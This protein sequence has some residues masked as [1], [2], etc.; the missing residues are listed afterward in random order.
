MAASKE[1]RPPSGLTILGR[2]AKLLGIGAAVLIGLLLVAV[3]A[4]QLS[5]VRK[6]ILTRAITRA[7]QSVTGE[8]EVEQ[9]A[10]PRLTRV[11][12][13]G[14]RW[15]DEGDTLAAAE[16]V[17]LAFDLGAL[18]QRHLHVR[19][20]TLLGAR[21]DLPA[22]QER[23]G[24][25]E[26][27]TT[28]GEGGGLPWI[29]EG[30]MPGVPSLAADHIEIG[31]P[32]ICLSPDRS[33]NDLSL[34]AS[35]DVR[36]GYSRSARIGRFHFILPQDSVAI[37]E[38][39]LTYT[40]SGERTLDAD[41]AGR[42]GPHWPIHLTASLERDEDLQLFL[43]REEGVPPPR[44]EG[45]ALD[46]RIRRR[47]GSI[48]GLAGNARLEIPAVAELAN[49]PILRRPLAGA[50]QFE[51]IGLEVGGSV[52]WRREV[53]GSVRIDVHPGEWMRRGH[54]AMR[55]A[56][57]ELI[58]DSIS[59]ELADLVVEGRW[60]RRAAE[61]EGRIK[62]RI[63][64]AEWLRPFADP[65][66]LPD[67]VDLKLE[68]QVAG[69]GDALQVEGRLEGSLQAAGRRLDDLS[70]A[71]SGSTDPSRPIRFG[72]A[73]LSSNLVL[74]SAGALATGEEMR[75]RLAPLRLREADD[76]DS[77][78]ADV[79]A[80]GA[81]D[82]EWGVVTY[83]AAGGRIGVE[84]VRVE[85]SY[86]RASIS[87]A[88][89]RGEG[90]FSSEIAWT[91]PPPV[92]VSRT[93]P[94]SAARSRLR[95]RWPEEGPYRVRAE[96]DIAPGE[97]G[98]RIDAR[99]TLH[100]PGPAVLAPAL[101]PQADAGDLGPLR[102]TATFQTRPEEPAWRAELDLSETDWLEAFILEASGGAR[103]RVDTLNLRGL[104]VALGARGRISADSLQAAARL[105]I[106]N[107]RLM[108]RLAPAA[109]ESTDAT[110]TV[111]A[112]ASGSPDAPRLEARFE[113]ALER[114]GLDLPRLEGSAS[115]AAQDGAAVGLRLP[116]SFHLGAFF[117]D[118]AMAYARIP[119]DTTAARAG[120]A[121]V[122]IHGDLLQLQAS[123]QFER[124]AGWEIKA[125][126]FAVR[127]SDAG[128]QAQTPFEIRLGGERGGLA[129]DNVDLEGGLGSIKGHAELDS[130]A[131]DVELIA[132]LQLPERPP[133]PA[134]PPGLWPHSLQLDLRAPPRDTLRAELQA[135]GLHIGPEEDVTAVLQLTQHSR[136]IAFNLKLDGEGEGLLAAEGDYPVTIQLSPWKLT[137]RDTA[138][139]ARVNLEQFPLPAVA[140]R[141]VQAP[142]YL[143]RSGQE[144]GPRLTALI[145]GAGPPDRPTVLLSGEV[146][147]PGYD[148]LEEYIV[149]VEAQGLPADGG[150]VGEI[151]A[152]GMAAIESLRVELDELP[153]PRPGLAA[154]VTGKRKET[155]V[156]EGSLELPPAW[157]FAG[158]EEDNG[159]GETMR[160][161]LSSDGMSLEDLTPLVPRVRGLDGELRFD[162]SAEGPVTDPG[163]DGRMEIA[164]VRVV[165]QDDTRATLDGSVSM[166]GTAAA[167]EVDG[168]I[169]I[170]NGRIQIPESPK[171][172]HPTHGEALLR[173]ES[174]VARV[175][176][177]RARSDTIPPAMRPED[178]VENG[179][180][181][182][183]SVADTLGEAAPPAQ[184]DTRGNEATQPAGPPRP[185]EGDL[186]LSVGIDIPSGV[187]LMGRGLE[188]ELRG[189][190]RITRRG[191]SL[192]I[193]GTLH[194][195]RGHMEFHG[196]RLEVEK[197]TVTFYGGSE[198]NPS[199]DLKLIKQEGGVLA[200]VHIT[201]TVEEPRL[202]LESEPQMPQA[203]ILSFIMF[204]KSSERLN[205]EQSERLED[206]ALAT[207]ED[208]AAARL[209]NAIGR[210]LGVDVLRYERA[211]EDSLGR[212][213]TIGKYLNPNLLVK[214]EQNLENAK[215]IGV[216]VEYYLGWGF[217][218]EMHSRRYE[219]DGA[220]LNWETDF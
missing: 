165:L 56:P 26:E 203:D 113:G 219:Q 197:G 97:E 212:S 62:A 112:E 1:S 141:P 69:P 17:V 114:P 177:A 54:A 76:A 160:A 14:L 198:L 78:R 194:A 200:R 204:G 8:L 155:A 93:A 4:L 195:Q 77:V 115:Y 151:Q 7:D 13:N 190:L 21:V 109:A 196:R 11:E 15:T 59:V 139:F 65:S 106:E 215:G 168:Q 207:A 68:A 149:A 52:A 171:D 44:G 51:G 220:V 19:E 216:V 31:A 159:A 193:L 33:L 145:L 45:L 201:G 86:G 40:E 92:L 103:T 108:R 136:R 73:V 29:R 191:G 9:A 66:S 22:L 217:Q 135:G 38:G 218:L 130:A 57:D 157:G 129:I 123:A 104:G 178:G 24:S 83:R 95:A 75:L 169:T 3:L 170:A 210:Q 89:A 209:T 167:P 25:A 34:D 176:R 175:E 87:G 188:V 183:P 72:L 50:P 18:I 133:H 158:R 55:F 146:T 2:V 122:E 127:Y 35:F 102:G 180:E 124:S 185:P 174:D 148:E 199:L 5:G 172:L 70:L 64:G 67:S 79:P 116:R 110:L 164:E 27:D 10:W 43:L 132:D 23:L 119:I 16:R 166:G 137:R 32:W 85:S 101:M 94:D 131:A 173:A 105:Q 30:A 37:H 211:A 150:P 28:T 206:R 214:Y 187:W 128:L 179:E 49:I 162:L 74:R 126:T 202:A 154:A 88:M 118:S 121:G 186:A 143:D 181:T 48:S 98:S 208:F 82:E 63:E 96:V 36:R 80:A 12:L 153:D 58:A 111:T 61:N 53:R 140:A 134:L 163:L 47:E 39:T 213:V 41:F 46:G 42:L 71:V 84:E 117:A 182:A 107:S 99:G 125:D 20:L 147:F 152:A 138:M 184:E 161:G 90:S 120:R 91:E 192:G 100:L 156:F 189:D 142:G 6:E 60:S 81:A 144:R 205:A